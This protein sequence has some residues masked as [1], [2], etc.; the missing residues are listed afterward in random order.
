MGN[1]GG[2]EKIIPQQKNISR[3]PADYKDYADFF[4]F[5]LKS[6]GRNVESTAGTIQNLA[7]ILW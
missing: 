6:T 7:F 4:I 5:F 1:D 3:E 2:L